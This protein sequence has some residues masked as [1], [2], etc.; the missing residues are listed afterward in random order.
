LAK[1]PYRALQI[2]GIPQDNGV[3]SRNGKNAELGILSI[4]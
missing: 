1:R 3:Y 2:S 4:S